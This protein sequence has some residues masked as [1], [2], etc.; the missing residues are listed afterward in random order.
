MQVRSD[1]EEHVEDHR[2]APDDRVSGDR[3]DLEQSRG[4]HSE[5][6][7]QAKGIVE[8]FVLLLLVDLVDAEVVSFR[9]VLVEDEAEDSFLVDVVL[10]ERPVLSIFGHLVF[11]IGC[12]ILW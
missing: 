9:E 6:G 1:V 3:L 8:V 4:G 2:Q 10:S 12:L 7:R 11:T 5:D